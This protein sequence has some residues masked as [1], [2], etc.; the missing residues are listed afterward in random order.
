MLPILY[1]FRRCPNAIRT[2]MGLFYRGIQCE[3]R[4]EVLRDKVPE[5]LTASPS[6]TVPALVLDHQVLDESLDLMLWA[7]AQSD[8]MG[9]LDM[10]EAGYALVKETNGPFK[11]ELDRTNSQVAILRPAK[12]VTFVSQ[13]NF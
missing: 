2:P 11:N 1:S 3:L 10:P 7:L 4:E 13:W 8:P 12:T 9:W 6:G 5:F